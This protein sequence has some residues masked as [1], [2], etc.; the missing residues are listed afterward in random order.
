MAGDNGWG[1]GC[2]LGPALC[3]SGAS[4]SADIHKGGSWQSTGAGN[5]APNCDVPGVSRDCRLGWGRDYMTMMGL[6]LSCVICVVWVEELSPYG[7]PFI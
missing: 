1:G 5:I 2:W 3:G 4:S 6:M 7:A